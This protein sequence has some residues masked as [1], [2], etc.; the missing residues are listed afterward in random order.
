MSLPTALWF[1]RS[2][3]Y[4]RVIWSLLLGVLF[5]PSPA[6]AEC[7]AIGRATMA[8]A[9]V[10][11]VFSGNVVGLNQ[12]APFGVRVTFNVDHAWKGSAPKRLDVYVWQLDPE[13]PRFEFAERYVVLATKMTG[14]SR[15][16]VGLTERDAAAF[17]PIACGAVEYSAAERSGTIRELGESQPPK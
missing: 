15:E 6:H 11:L 4:S 7:I 14:R 9:Q 1:L 3:P 16:G 12:V 17:K 5:I 2:Q 10:E 8:Q 13:M